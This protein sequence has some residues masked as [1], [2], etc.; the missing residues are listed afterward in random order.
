MIDVSATISPIKD[1]DGNIIGASKIARDITERK[2]AEETLS[3]QMQ[4]LELAQVM[5]R[6][7]SGHILPLESR[8]GSA[9][10]IFTG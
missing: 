4:V 10:W 1:D 8:C 2:R 7:P 9:L 3:E 6:D 5:I